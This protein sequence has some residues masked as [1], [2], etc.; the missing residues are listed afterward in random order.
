MSI[1]DLPDMYAWGMRA[2]IS[3]KS[4]MDMLKVLCNTFVAIVTTPVGWMAQVIVT[5]VCGVIINC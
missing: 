3:G 5:L 4:W 2:F 1:G